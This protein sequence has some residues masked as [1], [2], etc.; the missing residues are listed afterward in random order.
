VHDPTLLT[1]QV[2]PDATSQLLRRVPLGQAS[3]RAP[4]HVVPMLNPT[5]DNPAN[6]VQL[7]LQPGFPL[8]PPQA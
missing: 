3:P 8:P 6:I 5:L 7:T 4:L 2:D 1:K